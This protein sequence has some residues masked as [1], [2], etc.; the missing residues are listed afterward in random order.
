MSIRISVYD[1]FA[2]TIPGLA[3][4]LVTVHA[5]VLFEVI[6]LSLS[7]LVDF[8]LTIALSL[9]GIGYVLGLLIDAVADRWRKLFQGRNREGRNE[10]FK[11]FQAEYP[12]L[13][14]CFTSSDYYLLLRVIKTDSLE[15]AFD[16]EMHN[17]TS[18]MLHNICL[19]FSI[20]SAIYTVYIFTHGI[21]WWVIF[22]IG[23][24]ILLSRIALKRSTQRRQWFYKGILQATAARYLEHKNWFIEPPKDKEKADEINS[25]MSKPELNGR[26][27][28]DNFANGKIRFGK[29]FDNSG[30]AIAIV[31]FGFIAYLFTY[32]NKKADK[33]IINK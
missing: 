18:I 30:L 8:P 27:F 26:Y 7:L 9:I 19:A 4:I 22:G 10:A 24:S 6:Q 15:E 23:T 17:V 13:H 1:F 5:L 31:T 14:P 32:L 12:L 29:A 25:D 16:I 28:N 3:Y 33:N 11:D 20:L 21:K 2:Y